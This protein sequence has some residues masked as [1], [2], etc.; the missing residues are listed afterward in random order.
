MTGEQD[1]HARPQRAT[2]PA[3]VDP[4]ARELGFEPRDVPAISV[5]AMLAALFVVLFGSMVALARL[6]TVWRPH[7]KTS[8]A[9]EAARRFTSP[10]P[11]LLAAQRMDRRRL[12]AEQRRR[13]QGGE[14]IRAAM[15]EVANGGWGEDRGEEDK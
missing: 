8:S 10:A 6:Q 5:A 13:L 11:P 14:G 4:Q 1:F 2:D 9:A 15:Q 3:N 12:E 7:W